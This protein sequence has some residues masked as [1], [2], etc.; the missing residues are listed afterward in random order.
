MCQTMIRSIPT[1]LLAIAILSA[2][3]AKA[4]VLTC[5]AFKTRLGEALH[6][7]GMAAHPPFA[8]TPAGTTVQSGRR[9]DWSGLPGLSGKLTCGANDAFADFYMAVD[10]ATRPSHAVPDDLGAFRDLSAASICALS[11]GPALA[12]RAMMTA[13]TDD[14][15]DDYE[16]DLEKHAPRPRSLQ[17]YDFAEDLDATLLIT[18]GTLSWAIGPGLFNTVDSARPTLDPHDRDAEK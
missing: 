3:A 17:D 10:P 18:P 8:F 12:C 16:D 6:A 14:A 5:A 2:T 1:A 9:Y 11:A 15:I 4:E 7:S 13:M